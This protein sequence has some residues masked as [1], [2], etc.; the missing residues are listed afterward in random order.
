MEFTQLSPAHSD[1]VHD[2]VFDFYGR[3]FATCAADKRI[4]V[5]DLVNETGQWTCY[6]IPRA[7][8]DSIWRLS[9]AHP[10]FGQLIASCSEDKTI[11]VWEEQESVT[12]LKGGTSA[13]GEQRDRWQRKVQLSDSKKSVN[14]VKF[15]PRNLGLRI[16]AASA[17]GTVR[18]YEATDVF[19]LNYWQLQESFTVEDAI[20][21]QD[22]EHGVK[23][24]SWNESP[25]EP[26]KI[27]VGSFSKKATVWTCDDGGKWR[28]EC[29][30]GEHHGVVHDIAWAP[31]MGR[32]YHLIA[33]ASRENCF[34][35]HKLL[36]KEDGSLTYDKTQT[37]TTPDGSAVW[38]VSWNATGT[39]LATSAEDGQLSLYR[40][41]FAG[42]WVVVQT[43]PSTSEP[44][45]A[46]YKTT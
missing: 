44:A 18:I 42:D 37:V 16:A 1:V 40:K 38:R 24:I 6:D 32:S 30:L 31:V 17:D 2:I 45:R 8:N 39:V 3:R 26:A 36:R 27:A 29:V 35:V 15:A 21:G 4:K 28:E 41:N 46:F 12:P 7:H 9:W 33:T 13:L 23:C 20:D 43:L 14:D 19:S 10:E 22:T 5:W 11:C 34:R 25:F